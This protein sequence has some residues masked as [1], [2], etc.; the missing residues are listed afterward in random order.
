MKM[1]LC[2]ALCLVACSDPTTVAPGPTTGSIA[3]MVV[4]QSNNQGV[5]GV[6]IT[7]TSALDSSYTAQ[8]ATDS[9]G[10][11]QFLAVPAG[12]GVLQLRKLPTGCDSLLVAPFAVQG[13]LID[14]VTVTLPCA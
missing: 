6:N 14:S 4:L 5:A 7:A 10:V 3:G 12:A 8:T 2:I 13:G 1:T 9:F 11:F